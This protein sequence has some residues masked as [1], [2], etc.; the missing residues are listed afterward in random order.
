MA[1]TIN[2]DL[3][4]DLS[5]REAR[6]LLELCGWGF[7]RRKGS[8]EMWGHPDGRRFLL[9]WKLDR[10][11]SRRAKLNFTRDFKRALNGYDTMKPRNFKNG[12]GTL[13]GGETH[14]N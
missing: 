8:H 14:G 11:P 5:Y 7:L 2:I 10:Y 6:K 9:D 3:P 12:N 4:R 13:K 1:A